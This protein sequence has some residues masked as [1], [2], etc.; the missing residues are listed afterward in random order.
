V[1]YARHQFELSAPQPDGQPL[2]AHLQ[3]AEEQTGIV[4]N[5]IANAPPM[6]TGCVQLWRDFLELHGSRNSAGM[7]VSRITFSDLEAW[8][9]VR[10][11]QL[12]QWEIDC[13]RRIDD[14]W[15]S[16]FAP[17]PETKQ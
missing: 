2:L 14:L 5:M 13:I 8:Q 11:V 6:P 15:L 1:T 12:D 16:D 9:G 10:G 4:H 7:G 3:A 17:K